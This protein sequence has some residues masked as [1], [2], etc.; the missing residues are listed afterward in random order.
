VV[1]VSS[2]P[3]RD[4]SQ[5]ISRMGDAIRES[6]LT[7]D[8]RAWA[9]DVFKAHGFDGR[10]VKP[11]ITQQT[12][13]LLDAVRSSTTYT[14]DPANVEWIQAPHVTLCLR[15]VCFPGV[16]CDDAAV[17]LA[18]AML[19]VGLSAQIVRQE[20]G[21]GMQEHVLVGIVDEQGRRLYAD[22][23]NSTAPVYEGS[24]AMS[25]EWT[26]PLGASGSSR[27]EMPPQMVMLSGTPERAIAQAGGVWQETRYGRRWVHDGQKWHAATGLGAGF[28][29]PGDVLAYRQTWD[30]YVLGMVKAA[31]ACGALW[32]AK[33]PSINLTQFATPPD[34][35]TMTLWANGQ[36]L[37][38]DSLLTQWN[39]WA[40]TPDWQVIAN[41]EDILKD[42]QAT[43]EKA[44]Q[45]FGPEV[46]RDCP[47]IV[48]PDP[49]SFDLQA[50]T[51]GRIEGMGIVA[52][53]MLQLL[54]I[55][56]SGALESYG[57]IGSQIG[58]AV[59]RSF[60][61]LPWITIGVVAV[62]GAYVVSKVWPEGRRKRAA[63]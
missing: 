35:T 23:A 27:G 36:R 47:S 19:S 41:A 30:A 5:S 55:G 18:A 28:F 8:L 12:Q 13:A 3:Y 38:A 16:D 1:T 58:K 44:G 53:G 51:I 17:A 61:V 24:K 31:Q 63:A 32:D 49:P 62:A 20:F 52:H 21:M 45:L 50:Q 9:V 39:K 14:S 59:S 6:Y 46:A 29:T 56:A 43:V 42:F 60:D 48:L 4:T 11:T 26:D 2:E 7:P 40:S 22:P 33:D 34:A 37:N 15:D 57:E 10:N 25:E 54:G